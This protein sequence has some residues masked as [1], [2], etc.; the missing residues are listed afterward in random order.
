MTRK[1]LRRLEQWQDVI[2]RL[3]P[4]YIAKEERVLSRTVTFQVC[5]YCNLA[6]KYC[7]QI[8][9][10]KRSMS[11]DVAKQF[12]DLLLSGNKGFS[13]YINPKISPAIVLEFIGGEPFLEIELIDKIVDYFRERTIE[14]MH[15]W[16]TNYCISICSNGV[17]YSDKRVQKF[18]N[19]NKDHMSFSITIDGNKELHDSCRVFPDGRP[20]YDIAVAGANDWIAKGNYMGSKITIAPGN[21]TYLYDAI[22]HMVKLGYLDINAN[23]VYEKGWEQEHAVEFYDQLKMIADYF[24]DNDL[25]GDIYCSLFEEN[26]FKPKDE[27]DVQNWCGGNALM[28]ACDPDGYL[29]PCIRYM[30]SS[31]GDSRPPMRIGSVFDGL[32]QQTCHMD[33][34]HCL[35]GIDRRTQS[36]DECFYCP[37]GEGCAWCFKAGTL[38]ATPNGQVPIENIKVGDLVITGGG[39]IETVYNVNKRI[40]S[41]TLSIKAAGIETI[42]TTSEHPFLVKKFHR[43]GNNL[44]YYEPQWI[45]AKDIKTSDRIGIYVPPIGEKHIDKYVAYLAGRYVGD[46]WKVKNNR[47]KNEKYLYGICCSH[48]ETEELEYYFDKAN[49]TYGKDATFRTAQQYNIHKV[50]RDANKNNELLI[51]LIEDAGRY[52]HGK[53]VPDELFYCDEETIG[54]F[55]KGYIDADGYYNNKSRDYSVNTTSKQ[56]IYDVATLL[57]MLGYNPNFAVRKSNVSTIQGREV[58]VKTSYELKWKVDP[59]RKY[60]EYDKENNIMWVN[61][62]KIQKEVPYE[63]YNLSVSNEHTF[64]ANGVIVHNCSGYNYQEFGTPDKRATYICEMHKARSLANVYFWNKYYIKNG[65]GKR[66]KMYCPKEW[67]LKIISNEE[68]EM[69]EELMKE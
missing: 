5:D 14:L 3:Y 15:P 57:R 22:I 34:I 48:E 44:L 31:L 49:V 58:N 28:L 19:K 29:Y 30:E 10:S 1:K 6:C 42:Y 69:L 52:A 18:L 62:G 65:I 50:N 63:V 27:D 17:L 12:V 20:S 60:Y 11:F 25:V 39:H 33:C 61:V 53:K 43:S 26:F 56:L 23:C 2:A 8:N 41:D 36:T 13:D 37:I 47:C 67:A 35:K 32:G 68:Y 46:G 54:W 66:F 16:A 38:V 51:S 24:L 4:E 40:A 9:K 7:Y 55:L 21:L 59:K 64:L 45:S